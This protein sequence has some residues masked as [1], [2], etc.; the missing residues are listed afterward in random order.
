MERADAAD[1]D[2]DSLNKLEEH[3]YREGYQQGHEHGEL[4]GTFEGRELGRDKGFEAWEEVGFYAGLAQMWRCLIEASG[5][6]DKLSRKQLKQ[7]QHLGAL[8]RLTAAF[9][10]HNKPSDAADAGGETSADAE[11]GHDL[12]EDLSKLD[13]LALL[14]RIRA[15]YRLTCSVL[16]IRPR[17][18]AAPAAPQSSSEPGGSSFARGGGG[19][20][21][22]SKT[23]L[24]A[25]RMVDPTQLGY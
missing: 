14:E 21:A 7:L 23:V 24:V 17:G 19:F 10:M 8:E 5:P 22:Q 3:A 13:M 25:G 2:F 11:A 4:H 18:S 15:R 6:A 12:D 9:P 16:G 1:V 20:Q